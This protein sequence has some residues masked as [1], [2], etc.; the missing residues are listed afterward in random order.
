MLKLLSLAI[1][2][3]GIRNRAKN[4]VK[5]QAKRAVGYAKK[6]YVKK[7]GPNMKNIYKDVMMLKS[8]V[9]IEKKKIDVTLAAT[10][11]GQTSGAGVTG[12]I[13]R[14]FT[15]VIAQGITGL[16]RNGNSV[17]LVSGCL[18]LYFNQSVNAVNGG[19]I[20]WALV[21]KPDNAVPISSFDVFTQYL[22]N[23]PF[24]AVRDYHSSRD[25]EYF[26][27][28]RVIAGG[29]VTLTPDNLTGSIS[30]A[31]RKIPLKFNHHLKYNIDGTTTT[32][33]NAFFFIATMDTGDV[34]ALTGA[35][36]QANMRWYYTDN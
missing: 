10:T 12:G 23:N 19:K 9:N 3:P 25:P 26:T 2:M 16:T 1:Y 4:Y 29:V 6:R 21:C 11:F 8:L 18:D 5:K 20:R 22:E 34:V 30:F 24:S 35:Q 7:G 33:K 27:S 14:D 31:Q 15:P 17:K 28:L 36:V 13:S 32:S